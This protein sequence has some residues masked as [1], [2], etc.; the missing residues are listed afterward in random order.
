MQFSFI[1]KGGDYSAGALLFGAGSLPNKTNLPVFISQG[2][3]ECA[4]MP[5]GSLR[6]LVN[7]TNGTSI[8]IFDE[9]VID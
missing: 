9:Y 7:I 2:T 6:N 4:V 8:T 1:V 5:D 3:K